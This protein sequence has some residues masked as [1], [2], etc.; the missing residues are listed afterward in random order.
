MRVEWTIPGWPRDLAARTESVWAMRFGGIQH[1]EMSKLGSIAGL[2]R[3]VI[4][5]SGRRARRLTALREAI[6]AGTYHVSAAALAEALMRSM[7][8]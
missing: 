1:M 8:S 4:E 7:R 5:E 3:R 6:A 2:V